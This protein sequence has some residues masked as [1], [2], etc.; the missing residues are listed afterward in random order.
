MTLLL[1]PK[2]IFN[3]LVR[4]YIDAPNESNT[5]QKVGNSLKSFNG[6]VSEYFVFHDLAIHTYGGFQK[7]VNRTLIDDADISYKVVKLSNGYLTF[8]NNHDVDY[9]G[10][11]QYLFELKKTCDS[12]GS[13]LIYVNKIS[14]DTEDSEILP[15]Y[16][17]YVYYSHF[18][19]IKPQLEANGISVLDFEDTIVEQNIDK[20]S[21]FFKT[22]HHWTPKAGLWV[23]QIITQKINEEY[24]WNLNT[25]LLNIKNFSIEKYP[26]SFL[27]SQGKRVGALYD[28]VDD[29]EVIKPE[30]DTSLSVNIEDIYFNQTGT[31]EETLL[32][33]ESI[34]PDNLLNKDDTAYDT[35]MRGNHSLVKIT[36]N[37]IETGKS[38]LLILDSYGCVVA[39]YLALEFKNLDCID[40][41]SYSDSVEDYIKVTSPDIIIYSISGYQYSK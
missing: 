41:R 40:I 15:L 1:S 31:F 5:L 9:N 39:P 3:G 13:K 29:F 19:Y 10:L 36:N 4:G 20:Y 22:D 25:D 2:Q 24:N 17:P 30:F 26:H 32:H 34:T 21:L 38:A 27:G 12:K 33:E 28:G 35:Y 14:K 37:N 7:L 8:K 11:K 18:K 16:Y 6:K 23:S